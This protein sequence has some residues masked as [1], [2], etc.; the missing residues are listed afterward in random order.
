MYVDLCV[1]MCANFIHVSTCIEN[2]KDI[3]QI[4]DGDYLWLVGSGGI[5]VTFLF[6]PVFLQFFITIINH[7]CKL[8]ENNF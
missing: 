3:L 2:W 7:L 6:L 1:C 8:G 5:F 4:T